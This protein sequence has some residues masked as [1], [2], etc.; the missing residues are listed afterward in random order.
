MQRVGAFMTKTKEDAIQYIKDQLP[1]YLKEVTTSKNKMFVCPNCGSGTKEHGTA[2]LGLFEGTKGSKVGE[3]L[4]KCQSCGCNGDIFNLIQIVEHLPSASSAFK[5][6]LDHYHIWITPSNT[7]PSKNRQKSVSAALHQ[8]LATAKISKNKVVGDYSAFCQEAHRH[9]NETEYHRG[10]TPSTLERFGV[11]YIANWR[12]DES[13][14]PSPRLII[15]FIK[16]NE[17]GS[18]SFVGYTARLAKENKRG[19]L[20][21]GDTCILNAEALRTAKRRIFVV[22]GAI[23]AMSII[24][25]GGEAIGINGTS[26]VGNLLALLEK[27]VPVQPLVLALD[28]DKEESKGEAAAAK[29]AEG[30][31][32]LKTPFCIF[33]GYG[34]YKDANEFLVSDRDGLR[35]KVEAAEALE[36]DSLEPI[37]KVEGLSLATQLRSPYVAVRQGAVTND[38]AKGLLAKRDN[39]VYNEETRTLSTMVQEGFTFSII[40]AT[41]DTPI[42]QSTVQTFFYLLRLLTLNGVKSSAVRGNIN[43]YMAARTLSDKKEAKKQLMRDFEG[44]EHLRGLVT[45]AYKPKRADRFQSFEFMVYSGKTPE[46]AKNGDFVF[47]FDELFFELYQSYQGDMYLPL[48][49]FSIN[50]QY[51]PN[52]IALL[53]KLE[54]H[55]R[56]NRGK[57][58][59]NRIKVGTLL[60]VCPKI[61]TFDEVRSQNRNICDRIYKPLIRDLDAL[62]EA[63]TWDFVVNGSI[64][65]RDWVC[66]LSYSQFVNIDI[67]FEFKNYPPDNNSRPLSQLCFPSV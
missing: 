55:K 57:G 64:A 31:R 38:M 65:S 23:D 35:R 67:V 37:Q 47:R 5:Y 42:R 10:L 36:L 17:D 56:L 19:Y 16:F 43:E 54:E 61:P 66:Q 52:S 4:W 7:N 51:N 49:F 41:P 44:I 25:V 12:C 48:L 8:N 20:N 58:N 1:S 46:L 2:A 60:S 62:S 14:Y 21:Q 30:L 50:T 28:N 6:A 27:Q 29:L 53:L 32:R 13:K 45:A 39:F 9:I 22:E 26:G 34:A 63:L 40:N 33:D 3:L 59:E 11:G 18:R 24:D 15:P